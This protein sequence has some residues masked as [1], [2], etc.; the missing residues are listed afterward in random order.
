M[1]QERPETRARS[2]A[3]IGMIFQI[4]L[5]AFYTILAVW[6]QSQAMWAL[7][8][9]TSLGIVIWLTLL[10]VYHQ[11]VA[12]QEEALETDQ[13]R[14][15]QA[16]GQ[17]GE[18]IFDVTSEEMLLARRRLRWMYRWLVPAAALVII[19]ALVGAGL[20]GWS[21]GLFKP[22]SAT[23]WKDVQHSNVLMWFLGGAAFLSFLLSRYAVGMAKYLEWQML[24]AGA[25]YLMGVTLASVALAATLGAI[26]FVQNPYPEHVL[27]YALRFLML[28]LAA[29]FALNLL[30]DFYRPR[31]PDEVPRPS[32][33]SRLL[34]LFTEPGG[35]ARSIADA[36]NYQFG[37]EVS[38]TWFYK[39][40]ERSAVPLA[41]FA[42]L[43][44]VLAS[45][46]VF[47]SADEVVVVERFGRRLPGDLEP[48]LHF[49]LPWPVDRAY[50][51]G[52]HG[53]H[54]L[55]VGVK[56]QEDPNVQDNLILWTNQHAQEA[57]LKVLV[58]TPKLAGF[59]TAP[60]GD[61]DRKPASPD[62]SANESSAMSE[63][64][65]A[66]SVSM[67]RVAM[68]IQYEIKEAYQWIT[69]Y[70]DPEAALKALAH[71]E[72]THYFANV[73]VIGVLGTQRGPI[74]KALWE[75]MQKTADESNL[76]IRIVFL[77]LQG[78]HPPEDTAATFQE[79][80][81]AEQKK[82]ATIRTA[83]ADYNKRLS[84]V[85]GDVGRA[86]QLAKAIEK[87]NRLD[88][89][90]DATPADRETAQDQV[91]LLFFGSEPKRIRPVG[92]SAQSRIA[93]ARSERWKM[94]NEAHARAVAFAQEIANKQAAPEAYYT[95]RYL[96]TVA[97][98]VKGIRKYLLAAEGEISTR[99]FN[100]DIKDPANAPMDL[101]VEKQ[102]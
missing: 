58:A 19:V 2:V 89:D 56:Q 100:L 87:M 32:F 43:S 13:L 61:A 9:L 12:V 38:S 47:V 94:E 20:L 99:V 73:D 80:I 83:W 50:S 93:Q 30:L 82:N 69:T 4:V 5:A 95:R 72:I 15:Q 18:A 84:Q 53:V 27:A 55:I 17:V 34:G 74:E 49:K 46:L 1:M 97:E 76:G 23:T 91:Q 26:H 31:S 28:V 101:A 25:S 88:S 90:P 85:A 3:L 59:M 44:L 37:F 78:V 79:V 77:G 21:W 63:A 66:V 71:R 86:E 40:L 52:I 42:V 29:E 65:E 8:L 35:I 98:S 81:G 11:R 51:V 60:G 33:D 22:I 96:R 39:L 64:S 24:R 45:S 67:L 10:L 14:R 48:G 41:G 70:R 57:H 36:I 75:S 68:T 62:A 92:G 6:S 16:S 7:T 102:P 54:E